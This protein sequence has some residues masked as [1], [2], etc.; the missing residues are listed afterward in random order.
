MGFE[1]GG[2]THYLLMEYMSVTL[3]ERKKADSVVV[4]FGD[5]ITMSLP[6]NS[7]TKN[8]T[9]YELFKNIKNF[10]RENSCTSHDDYK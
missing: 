8:G 1:G 3:L 9:D 7:C 10:S 2:C 4:Y 5:P 6:Q